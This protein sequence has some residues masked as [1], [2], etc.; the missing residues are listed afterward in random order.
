MNDLVDTLHPLTSNFSAQTRGV[1]GLGIDVGGTKI[2]AAVVDT[3]SGRVLSKRV[4]PTQP[5]RGGDA[6]LD[7]VLELTRSL[8]PVARVARDPTHPMSPVSAIPIGLA[9][10]EL[11]DG[12]G[13][14]RSDYTV[15]WQGLPVHEHLGE[16]GITPAPA[17]V[18]ADIRAHA[19]AEARF[20]AGG[21]FDPFVFVSVGTGISS[22]LVQGGQPFAGA[23][24]NA[25]VLSTAPLTLVRDDGSRESQVMETFSS[26]AGIAQRFGV[27]HAEAVFGAAAHGDQRAL[28]VLTTAGE[29]LG[30]S[31]AFLANVLDP[32][33][34]IIGGGLGMTHGVYWDA[35][36]RTTREHI[37]A[38]STRDLP[39]VQAALGQDAGVIG[40]ATYATDMPQLR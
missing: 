35:L 31:I 28:Q 38:E 39:I 40:A 27:R 23:R 26:G 11:V 2:A 34:I 6:V 24:G 37:W 29:A 10:C 30:N 1:I 17:V 21:A 5:E 15:K 32:A 9:V 7:D 18:E 14:V 16:L 13:H 12:H 36:V 3:M 20:G 25:L 8:L 33:A 22:C 19:L 4:I